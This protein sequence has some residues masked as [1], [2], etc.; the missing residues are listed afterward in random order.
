MAVIKLGM[1]GGTQRYRAGATILALGRGYFG[2]QGIDVHVTAEGGR[3]ELV[4]LL[5]DE[6]IDV[7]LQGAS[8]EFF[9]SWD[10]SRPY[11]MAADHG[12][13]PPPVEGKA[14][15]GLVARTEL[16]TSGRLR[17]YADLRGLRLGL[18]P[19]K[20]DHDWE[21][22]EQALRRGGLTFDD[23]EVVICD[24][25]S[26]R[27]EALAKG[28]IDVTAVGRLRS[29]LE[30][31]RNGTFVVWKQSAELDAGRQAHTVVF[32]YPFWSERPEE[33]KAYLRAHLRAS[34]EY[35]DAFVH[36][37]DREGVIALLAR[38]SG[39]TPEELDRDMMPAVM[40]PD[41]YINV[42]SIGERARWL[43]E[44][45]ALPAPIDLDRLVDHRH[46]EAVLTDVGRY[47][48][49]AG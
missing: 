17:E 47:Q 44:Q 43:E 48:P 42:E 24:F 15:G 39:Y 36:G 7:C 31:A 49:P 25:G 40:N 28:T 41:G 29:V 23:V 18:S 46:L 22:F 11:I 26:G 9:K 3:R 2:D 37:V 16:V 14:G 30:G 20:G 21:S 13:N 12:S 27:H 8:L 45:G 38:E 19:I 33:A 34:R 5:A 1:Q 32:S 35:H 10:P 4:P 6:T